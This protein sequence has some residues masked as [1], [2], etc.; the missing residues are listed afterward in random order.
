[1]NDFQVFSFMMILARVSAFIAFFPL[2]G[3]RQLPAMVKAGLATALTVFWFG[4]TPVS[5]YA[6]EQIPT[7][8]AVMLIGQEVGIGWL[9]ATALGFL[10][11]PARIAGTYIGQEIGLSMEP[12]TQSGAESTSMM[13]SVFETFVVLLFFGLNLHHFLVLFLHLSL[14]QLAGKINMMNLPTEGLVRM[15]D[16]LAEYGF[17]I[18]APIGV[19]CM[20]MLIGLFFLSKAAPTMNLFSVGM[21]LRVGL[22]LGCVIIFMP[23]VIQ[24]IAMYLQRMTGDL[25]QLLGFFE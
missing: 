21:P 20:V 19:V 14:T 23:V 18:L 7:L 15:I 16:S 25:E 6:G 5:P 11:L 17:L 1:M 2:F 8:L 13:S 9:L 3:Q 12:V 24:S 22:G 4:T 10:L